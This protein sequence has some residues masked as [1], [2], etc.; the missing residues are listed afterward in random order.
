[1]VSEL[2]EVWKSGTGKKLTLDLQAGID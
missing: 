2:D 1:M